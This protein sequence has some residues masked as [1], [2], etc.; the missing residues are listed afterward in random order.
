MTVASEPQDSAEELTIWIRLRKWHLHDTG[1]PPNESEIAE[2][3]LPVVLD[4]PPHYNF[5]EY[6]RKELHLP[7][8]NLVGLKL[9]N[10]GGALVP[11]LSSVLKPNTENTPYI[12]DICRLHQTVSVIPRSPYSEH[13]VATIRNKILGLERRVQELERTAPTV[14]TEVQDFASKKLN[15]ELEFL[16]YKLEFLA[17]RVRESE[18]FEWKGLIRQTPTV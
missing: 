12:L 5:K 8:P 11:F 15:E 4:F 9:R 6:L 2:E 1:L 10:P 7:P 13:Y 16:D 17:A 14:L 3:L 18:P